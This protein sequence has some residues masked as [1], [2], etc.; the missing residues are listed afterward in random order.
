MPCCVKSCV[1]GTGG[2]VW[3]LSSSPDPSH[4]NCPWCPNQPINL[5]GLGLVICEMEQW[6]PAQVL[7]PVF[8]PRFITSVVTKDLLRA[9]SCAEN[10]TEMGHSA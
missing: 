5:L 3:A 1:Q 4:N 10:D 7:S 9:G 8:L 2:G 6:N